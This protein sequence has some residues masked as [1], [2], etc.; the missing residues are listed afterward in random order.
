VSSARSVR[1]TTAQARLRRAVPA[2]WAASEFWRRTSSMTSSIATGSGRGST[3]PLSRVEMSR[4]DLNRRETLCSDRSMFST[5]CSSSGPSLAPRRQ[6]VNR[7]MAWIGWRRSWLACARK[8]Y[9]DMLA[10]CSRS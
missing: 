1:T 9:L 10:S 7:L 4:S 8:R 3:R 6:A 2:I 5:I